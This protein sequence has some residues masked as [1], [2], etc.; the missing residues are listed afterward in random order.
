MD[1]L[2]RKVYNFPTKH[3]EGFISNEIKVLLKEYSSVIG[4]RFFEAL[5]V[6]TCRVIDGEIVTYHCDV[7][8]ALRCAIEDR[9][10]RLSEW[11]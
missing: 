9:D 11:D 6:N 10:I 5:G 7:L 1:N 4:D 8:T 3:K 2:K